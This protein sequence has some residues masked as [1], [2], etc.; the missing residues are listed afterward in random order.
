M[1]LLISNSLN[2]ITL[3]SDVLKY[4]W[5]HLCTLH[6]GLKCLTFCL[7]VSDK[8]TRQKFTGQYFISAELLE[9]LLR[10]LTLGKNHF[11]S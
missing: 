11:K 6:G 4:F 7:S 3:K 1:T 9:V 2:K 10:N 5:A 8:M